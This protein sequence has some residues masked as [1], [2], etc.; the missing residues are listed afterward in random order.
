[1]PQ[2][3]RQPMGSCGGVQMIRKSGE[4]IGTDERDA[5]RLHN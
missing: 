5:L 4:A 3:S 2:L 1:M